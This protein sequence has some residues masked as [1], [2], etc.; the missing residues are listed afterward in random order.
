MII[1]DKRAIQKLALF[2]GKQFS[3][4]FQKDEGQDGVWAQTDKGWGEA[5]Q[6]DRTCHWSAAII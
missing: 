6:K 2:G 3:E 5:L 4:L 1:N